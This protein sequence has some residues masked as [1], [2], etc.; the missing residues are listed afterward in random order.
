MMLLLD[1]MFLNGC[2]VLTYWIHYQFAQFAFTPEFVGFFVYINLLWMVV[3]RLFQIYRSIRFERALKMLF[4]NFAA[5]VVFFFLFL[6]YF[7]LIT[8]N[9]LNRDELK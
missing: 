9:Y 2:F 7:Q 3:S 8:F 6:M 4:I 1:L 5:I